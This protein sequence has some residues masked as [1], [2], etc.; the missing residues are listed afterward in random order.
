MWHRSSLAARR[1][2]HRWKARALPDPAEAVHLKIREIRHLGE[3]L[4]IE[5]EVQD[6]YGNC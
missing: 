5:S 6:V 4:L 1:Q 2:K 3:D